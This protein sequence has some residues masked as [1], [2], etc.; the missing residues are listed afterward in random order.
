MALFKPGN[1]EIKRGE[2][3]LKNIIGGKLVH[4]AEFIRFLKVNDVPSPAK[5]WTTVN[6]EIRKELK[7]GVLRADK[8]DERIFEIVLMYSP[9]DTLISLA[10]ADNARAEQIKQNIISSGVIAIQ[11][12]YQSSGIS[13]AALGAAAFGRNGALLGA[14]NEGEIK[15]KNTQLM[16]IENGLTVKSTGQVVLYGDVKEV[17]IGQKGFLH[18]IV[19]I[20][21]ENNSGLV[22]KV[23][24]VNAWAFK[25]I[26]EENMGRNETHNAADEADVLLKYA[27]LF[28]KG[29]LTREEFEA[30][31]HE[32][33]GTQKPKFCSNCGASIENDSAFCSNCGFNLQGE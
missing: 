4:N 11:I 20:V 33:M 7:N 5:V 23:A 21:A 24:N 30:K 22:C 14:L 3:Q 16:F 27:D 26:V 13:D 1:D 12:P 18:T 31:K 15:W 28:E 19:T 17:V 25:S 10:E 2:K 29:L 6:S 8:V 9:N 32:I